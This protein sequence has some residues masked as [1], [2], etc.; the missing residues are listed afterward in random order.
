MKRIGGM[1]R[2]ER[3]HKFG[4]LVTV[5]T[6]GRKDGLRNGIMKEEIRSMK[7]QHNSKLFSR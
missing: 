4:T 6:G 7:Q 5:R 2:M 1:M 3:F